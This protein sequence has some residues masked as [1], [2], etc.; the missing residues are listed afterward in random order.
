MRPEPTP[1]RASFIPERNLLSRRHSGFCLTGKRNLSP[2]LSYQNAVIFGQTGTGKSSIVLLPSLFSMQGSFIVHDNSGELYTK[3]ASYLHSKG[4][5]VLRLDFSNPEVSIGFNPLKRIQTSSDAQKLATSLIY[6][7]FGQHGEQFW[8]LQAIALLSILIQVL[9]TQPLY[10]RT[11]KS[12]QAMLQTHLAAPEKLHHFVFAHA[13]PQIRVAYEAFAGYEEKLRTNIVASA[14]AALTHMHDESIARVTSVDTWD[15]KT[16][17][18]QKTALFIQNP[19]TEQAY[20]STLTSIF[21]EQLW[22]TF[23]HALPEKRDLDTF[24][25]IDEASSLYLPSLA[26]TIA[27]IRKF[28]G[29]L[30]LILQNF[31]QLVHV[32]GQA[33]ASTIVSNCFAKVYL[34]GQPLETSV[35][36][37]QTLG[38]FEYTDKK[39]RRIIRPLMTAREIRM[40]PKNKALLLCG[41]HA[42]I[43]ATL[44]PYY[45]RRKYRKYAMMSPPNQIPQIPSNLIY[46]NLT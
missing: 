8:N 24:F 3:S 1:L 25:L 37:E 36:L 16:L 46:L 9:L 13:S 6:T 33:Q 28:R 30:M 40:M 5:R 15:M 10:V 19:V 18:T 39:G 11:L 26:T 12:V 20:L 42:P 7:S 41:N 43:K 32:Y 23:M 21:F 17:R 27:N 38:K 31:Q 44:I 35:E 34:T 14:L 4:Y 2:K 29:G 22:K 45:K